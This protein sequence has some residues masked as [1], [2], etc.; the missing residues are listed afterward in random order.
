MR[1]TDAMNAI[2]SAAGR[3]ERL[4]CMA[5]NQ[6]RRWPPGDL[7]I[8]VFQPRDPRHAP[9]A[10]CICRPCAGDASQ[11]RRVRRWSETRSRAAAE[12]EG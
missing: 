8:G 1:L 11:L 12:G 2:A 4:R 9:I 10:Y 7:L 3:G 5:C 6:L